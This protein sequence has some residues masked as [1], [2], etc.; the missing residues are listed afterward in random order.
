MAD[1][2]IR[3]AIGRTTVLAHLARREAARR[4][5]A[6]KLV[7]ARL[8]AATELYSAGLSLKA[9]GNTMGVDAKTVG[10][11]LRSNGVSLRPRP[12]WP[13]RTND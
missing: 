8:E 11:A 5:N 10:R 13:D 2:A 1:L 6:P 12:G 3:F 4:G 7:G 9:V